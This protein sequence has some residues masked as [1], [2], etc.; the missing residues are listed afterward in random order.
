LG[1]ISKLIL[2]TESKHPLHKYFM[3]LAERLAKEFNLEKE[4]RYEDYM[5]LIEHGDTNELGMAWL[6][7]LL[8]QTDDGKIVKVLTKPNLNEKGYLDE[9]RDYKL[10]VE[11]IK[12]MEKE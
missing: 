2:V 5:F 11:V 1:K 3:K 12:S 9:E 8:A 7:Q 10:A 4:I 6:P